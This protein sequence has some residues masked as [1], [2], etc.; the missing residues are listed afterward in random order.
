MKFKNIHIKNFRNFEDVIISLDNKN[1]FFGLN[2]I[3]KTNFLYAI[4]YIFDKNIRKNNLIDSDFH[5]KNTTK[6][7]EILISIDISD[8][9]DPDTDKLR[10][11]LKGP[12]L[13]S[14]HI[15]YIKLYAEFNLS[16]NM[17]FPILSWGG[18]PDELIEMSQSHNLYE[19]DKIFNIIYIDSYIN[20]ST[21]FKKNIS[22]LLVP[23]ESDNNIWKEITSNINEINQKLSNMD[24]IKQF[25]NNLLDSYKRFN[26]DSTEIA[27]VPEVSLNR[28]QDNL[29]PYIHQKDDDTLYPTSGDGRKKIVSY[30]LISLLAKNNNLNKIN[31]FLIEEPENHL[32]KSL[33]I[34]L[35]NMLFNDNNFNYLFLTTHSSYI[36]YEMDNVNLVRIYNNKNINTSSLLFRVPSN[37]QQYK[38]MLTRTLS[39]AIFSNKVLLVEGISEL[40]LFEKVL[41]VV[42]PNYEAK[43]IYILCVNGISFE[44]YVEIL[45]ALNI[46]TIIKTDN[47]L[48]EYEQKNNPNSYFLG[49]KRCNALVNDENKSLPIGEIDV[50]KCNKSEIINLKKDTYAKNKNLLDLIRKENK[51]YLSICDLEND[52]YDVLKEPLI[53]YLKQIKNNQKTRKNVVNYLQESKCYNMAKMIAYLTDDDCRTIYEHYNFAC[54]KEVTKTDDTN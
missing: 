30:S 41:S 23:T 29:I 42:Y 18:N 5:K 27:L 21:L 34:A 10:S 19:I 32:H 48:K 6:P 24:S 37:Y 31:I 7:V 54:L 3:G 25:E 46:E 39:E 49:F 11:I 45:T 40:L 52:L 35:S 43:G 17:A 44:K 47:D 22:K 26:D 14:E 15:L 28:F 20:L 16:E 9:Q 2:D 33:Q 51:I 36:L 1:I 53:S 38:K 4:R 12:L 13:S 50:S 8:T